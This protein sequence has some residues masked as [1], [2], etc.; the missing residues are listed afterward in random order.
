VAPAA[1]RAVPAGAAAGAARPSRAAAVPPGAGGAPA[2]APAG[3]AAAEAGVERSLDQVIL[4]YLTSEAEQEQ[5]ELILDDASNLALGQR[6]YLVLRAT[7][8]KSGGGVAGA[9][10]TVKMISTVDEPQHL[11]HGATDDRGGL[12]LVFD[13]PPLGRGTAALIITAASELGRAEVKQLL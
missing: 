11:A 8:S 12:R 3:R 4:E 6:A 9:Q 10:V 5:L 1:P 2:G 7:S 13:I